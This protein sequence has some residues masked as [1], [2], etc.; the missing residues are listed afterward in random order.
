[1]AYGA[2]EYG[3]QLK[4]GPGYWDLT[5][6]EYATTQ[7]AFIK[8]ADFND[9]L[10]PSLAKNRSFAGSNVAEVRTTICGRGS[11]RRT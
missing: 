5:D 7:R 2:T 3:V 1:M 4:F 8:V 9:F 11:I 6:P 10:A